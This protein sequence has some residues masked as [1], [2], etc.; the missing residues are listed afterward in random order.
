MVTLSNKMKKII[1]VLLMLPFTVLI[2]V[3][4]GVAIFDAGTKAIITAIAILFVFGAFLFL[5]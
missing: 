5:E 4:V 2:I 1:G 3:G